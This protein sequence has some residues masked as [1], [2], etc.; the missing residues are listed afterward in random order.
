MGDSF[1]CVDEKVKIVKR[2]MDIAISG[3]GL[4]ATAPLFGAIAL[5]VTKGRSK[6]AGPAAVRDLFDAG[7]ED[8]IEGAHLNLTLRSGRQ[9]SINAGRGLNRLRL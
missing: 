1:F 8:L 2:A 5:A 3:A 7:L 6:A 4:V 9:T